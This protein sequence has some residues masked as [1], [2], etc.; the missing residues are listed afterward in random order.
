MDGCHDKAVEAED[1]SS[2]Q[3][4]G[5]NR[6]VSEDHQE[7]VLACLRGLSGQSGSTRAR[8]ALGKTHEDRTPCNK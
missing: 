8:K 7:C 5:F 3:T 1:L 2:N 6:A 4:L